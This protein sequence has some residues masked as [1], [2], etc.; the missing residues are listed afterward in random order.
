[1]CFQNLLQSNSHSRLLPVPEVSYLASQKLSPT[2]SCEEPEL[3][4]RQMAT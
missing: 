3:G 4:I 1:V 2:E